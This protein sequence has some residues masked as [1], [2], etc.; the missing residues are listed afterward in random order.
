MEHLDQ[1]F[2]CLESRHIMHQNTYVHTILRCN[3]YSCVV[4]SVWLCLDIGLPQHLSGG[5]S[6]GISITTTDCHLPRTDHALNPLGC[7]VSF[8]V[9][10]SSWIKNC[11][12]MSRNFHTQTQAFRTPMLH[13]GFNLRSFTPLVVR[14][15]LRSRD[16]QMSYLVVGFGL[17]LAI[18]WVVYWEYPYNIQKTYVFLHMFPSTNSLKK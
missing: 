11:A 8:L 5:Y 12:E 15:D 16:S 18:H 13:R 2:A 9:V 4:D 3:M 7:W 6:L 10:E 14:C 1:I 17:F